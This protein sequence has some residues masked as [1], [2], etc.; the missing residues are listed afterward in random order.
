MALLGR[1]WSQSRSQLPWSPINDC[2]L[3]SRGRYGKRKRER[4]RMASNFRVTSLAVKLRDGALRCG[5]VNSR[6]TLAGRIFNSRT[7]S[8]R[9]C[10]TKRNEKFC[11]SLFLLLSFRAR[12]SLNYERARESPAA[13]R[14]RNRVCGLDCALGDK[15]GRRLPPS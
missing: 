12:S 3:S 4:E 6:R 9:T 2:D 13:K 1:R 7:Q 10:T 14:K 11:S 8:S 15:S 5:R